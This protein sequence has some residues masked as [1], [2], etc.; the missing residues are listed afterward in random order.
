M[1][2]IKLKGQ[3]VEVV[4][5][6]GLDKLG[7]ADFDKCLW[8]LVASKYRDEVG[9]ELSKEDFSLNDAED[10]KKSLSDRKRTTIDIDR[11]LIDISRLEF[12]ECISTLMAQIEMTCEGTLDEANVKPDDIASVFLAGG[13]TRMPC[14]VDCVNKVF[15]QDP[16]STVDVDEVVALGACL[17][18][19]YK[20]DGANLS[21]IQKKSLAK[22]SLSE[23]T[24]DYFG[25]IAVGV[26]E[27]KGQ[28][29]INSI[30][31][32]KGQALPCSVT[33]TYYTMFEGQT[34][35][36]CTITRSKSPETNPK[37]VKTIHESELEVP[38]NRPAGQEVEVTYSYDE[39]QIMHASFKDISSGQENPIKLSFASDKSTQSEIDK[40][41]VD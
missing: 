4:A 1:S 33:K 3:D 27:S 7:G 13:S 5:S 18:A 10:E 8:D 39:N 28:A 36:T 22:L 31:I 26:S 15:K 38:P 2:V 9:T 40:F 19:A 11:D 32:E 34:S 23:V 35:I 29:E 24:N 21:E 12:E 37:F 41:L 30:L 16:I 6:N 20:S 17:Y 14:V 25:T